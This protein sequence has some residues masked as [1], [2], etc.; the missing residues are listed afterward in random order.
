MKGAAA[1]LLAVFFCRYAAAVEHLC[2]ERET[3]FYLEDMLSRD[4]SSVVHLEQGACQIKFSDG[5]YYNI[6]H[7]LA[8]FKHSP[9]FPL[10]LFSE[11]FFS[12][13]EFLNF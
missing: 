7:F 10:P 3:M 11:L 2:S 5:R 13:P 4:I 8:I 9:L 1:L 6:Y 12:E